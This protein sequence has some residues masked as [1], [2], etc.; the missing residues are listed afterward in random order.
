V[1]SFDVALWVKNN[2]SDAD[3]QRAAQSS[4]L[5]VAGSGP[6]S[7]KVDD[8]IGV[9]MSMD[10]DEATRRQERDAEA[11]AKRQQNALPEWIRKSTVS[12]H[13]TASGVAE[14]AR[15]ESAAGPSNSNDEIL[16]GLGTAGPAR[17]E[18]SKV[19]IVDDVKP[20]VDHDQI[21]MWP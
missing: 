21:G 7:G 12:G 19:T 4:G 9:V 6:G 2:S 8:G 16:R 5:K 10:K 14:S 1:I 17:V 15:A 18:E 13:L 11:E 20:V 3:R